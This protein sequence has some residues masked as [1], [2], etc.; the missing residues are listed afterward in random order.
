MRAGRGCPTGTRQAAR[1]APHVQVVL[2]PVVVG[3]AI[4]SAFPKQAGVGNREAG[5]A[6]RQALRPSVRPAVLRDYR[7]TL[8]ASRV[9]MG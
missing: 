4:N 6:P 7:S 8:P 9:A 3:A 5:Q 2:L 1:P